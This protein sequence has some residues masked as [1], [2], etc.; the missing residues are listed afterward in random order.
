MLEGNQ[1][2]LKPCLHT[3]VGDTRGKR[4]NKLGLGEALFLEKKAQ[5][6]C[7]E[8]PVKQPDGA[9]IHIPVHDSANGVNDDLHGAVKCV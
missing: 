8:N 6:N 1:S 2:L 5:A 3:T 9:V 4:N 7:A